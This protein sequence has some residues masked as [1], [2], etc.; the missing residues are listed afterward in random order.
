MEQPTLSGDSHRSPPVSRKSGPIT[1]PLRSFPSPMSLGPLL[2]TGVL[3]QLIA[4]ETFSPSPCSHPSSAPPPTS[5]PTLFSSRTPR[6]P[7][8]PGHFQHRSSFRDLAVQ[9]RLRWENLHLPLAGGSP[10]KT[11]LEGSEGA[12]RC[13]MAHIPARL[14]LGSPTR[15]RAESHACCSLCIST[16][17]YRGP[18]TCGPLG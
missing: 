4:G 10:G 17:N 6:G 14:A 5:R 1:W 3:L 15:S 8:Q 7:H 9:A 12:G 16:H 18:S 11:P 2:F 13:P